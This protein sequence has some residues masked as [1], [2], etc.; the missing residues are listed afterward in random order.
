MIFFKYNERVPSV[1]KIWEPC[2]NHTNNGKKQSEM[3]TLKAQHK[4]KFNLIFV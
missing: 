1:Q 2:S 3:K 4:L